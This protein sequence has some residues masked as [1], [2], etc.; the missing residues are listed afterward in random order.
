ML[1]EAG[2]III[3]AAIETASNMLVSG[4]DLISRG[5]V[6]VRENEDLMDAA[7]EVV[8]DTLDKY[9]SNGVSDWNA[10]KA[11]VRDALRSFI[12]ENTGRT[13]VILPIFLEI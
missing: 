1:S 11:K 5:F 10:L 3:V 12:Y 13:P 7:K 6:Y 9:M 2:L 4:P 8:T